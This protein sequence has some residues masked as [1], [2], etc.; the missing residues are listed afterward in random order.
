MWTVDKSREIA[1]RRNRK[2]NP[3]GWSPLCCWMRLKLKMLGALYNCLNKD[4]GIANVYKLYKN[5]RRDMVKIKLSDEEE[6]WMDG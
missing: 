2:E 6:G 3:N 1:S 5:A 4:R